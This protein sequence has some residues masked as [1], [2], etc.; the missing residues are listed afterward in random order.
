MKLPLSGK[1]VR[2]VSLRPLRV[3]EMVARLLSFT[4]LSEALFLTQHTVSMQI[5]KLEKTIGARL[6]EQIGRNLSMT[7]KGKT[8]HQASRDIIKIVCKAASCI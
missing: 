4:F 7:A 2:R 1:L 3:F 6:P 8:L 5:R